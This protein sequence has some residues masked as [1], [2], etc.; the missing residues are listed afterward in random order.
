MATS[1]L[2]FQALQLLSSDQ[3]ESTEQLKELMQS[4]EAPMLES[5]A[6]SGPQRKVFRVPVAAPLI[7]YRK[8]LQPQKRTLSDSGNLNKLNNPNKR[9]KAL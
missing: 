7:N 3:A 9:T 6:N 2:F 1:K 4:C 8:E 5:K